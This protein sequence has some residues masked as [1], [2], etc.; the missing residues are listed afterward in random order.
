MREVVFEEGKDFPHIV[1]FFSAD[2]KA[3]NSIMIVIGDNFISF[4]LIAEIVFIE[5]DD[6]LFLASFDDRIK[7]WVAAAVGYPCISDLNEY[8]NFMNIFLDNSKGFMHVPRE[9]VDMIF[10][11]CDNFHKCQS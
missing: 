3:L 10:E 5:N 6:F 7:L 11:M 9:P 2:C 1:M 4:G 8:I